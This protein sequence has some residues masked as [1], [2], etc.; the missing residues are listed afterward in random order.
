MCLHQSVETMT[1]SDYSFLKILKMESRER[2]QTIE[3]KM[4]ACWNPPS[5]S[6]FC[7]LWDAWCEILYYQSEILRQGQ[8]NLLPAVL[9]QRNAIELLI[10]KTCSSWM[11]VQ[12]RPK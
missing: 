5:V 7:V 2:M 11:D 10:D 3:I 6:G 1:E 9:Q 8:V 12:C 4:Q